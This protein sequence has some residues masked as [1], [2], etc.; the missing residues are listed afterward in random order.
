MLQ[1]DLANAMCGLTMAVDLA[2]LSRNEQERQESY[3]RLRAS[4]AQV[5][6]LLSG[7]RLLYL[8]REGVKDFKRGDLAAFVRSLLRE[9]SVWREIPQFI[10]RLPDVMWCTFSPTL[11]RHAMFNLV[12]NAALYS[13]GTWVRVRLAPVR[14]ATWILSVAN[15]GPGISEDYLRYLFDLRH[16][17]VNGRSARKPGSCGLGLYIARMCLRAHG[18]NLRLISRKGLTVFSFPLVGV[19]QGAQPVINSKAISAA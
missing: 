15:G 6:D 2:G 12:S 10:I 7:M 16:K 8:N 14:G 13:Q 19:H 1:H 5:T 3:R 18:S 4:M 9:P 11:I 17:A